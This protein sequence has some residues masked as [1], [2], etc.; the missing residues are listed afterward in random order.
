MS[1]L[2]A[3]LRPS[4]PLTSSHLVALHPCACRGQY[5]KP[6]ELSRSGI[7]VNKLLARL[8]QRIRR[9]RCDVISK[10]ILL[11]RRNDETG[12]NVWLEQLQLKLQ[13]MYRPYS[14]PPLSSQPLSLWVSTKGTMGTCIVTASKWTTSGSRCPQRRVPSICT[15]RR[16]SQ[17][18]TRPT[19]Q[20]CKV[21]TA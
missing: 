10:L 3:S 14:L 12:H 2:P 19:K 20:P 16:L 11:H 5:V 9:C 15:A 1:A 18:V 17:E 13:Q 7:K 21:L 6:K 8:L 4:Q